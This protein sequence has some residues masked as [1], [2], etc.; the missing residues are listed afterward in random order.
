MAYQNLL[1]KLA[2]YLG[3]KKFLVCDE[4]KTV[5]FFFVE[6]IMLFKAWS[7]GKLNE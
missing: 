4:V 7:K 3:D 2:S 1:P 6:I 5:D